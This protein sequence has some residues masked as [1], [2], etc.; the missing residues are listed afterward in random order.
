MTNGIFKDIPIKQINYA[1]QN[2]AMR[3]EHEEPSSEEMQ[4]LA[5]SLK[6]DDIIQPILVRPIGTDKYEVIAGNRR[7][8]AAKAAGLR[9]IPA[10]VRDDLDDNRARRMAFVENAIR[11][12][13]NPVQKAKGIASLY[14]GR[15]ISKEMA[16]VMVKRVHDSGS[17]EIAAQKANAKTKSE[18]IDTAEF[19]EVFNS[20][21]L[22]ANTQY[23]YLQFVTALDESVQK[24]ISEMP[25]FARTKAT[26]LTHTRL[27]KEPEVQK[28]LAH[29]IRKMNT[30]QAQETV[31]QAVHDLE[32]G[33]ITKTKYTDGSVSIH[34]Y[35][36]E[37]VHA[38]QTTA[39]GFEDFRSSSYMADL[40][41]AIKK[42]I[43]ILLERPLGRG[44][45]EYSERVYKPKIEE[46]QQGLSKAKKKDRLWLAKDA[47]VL[48][49]VCKAIMD[50]AT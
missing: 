37:N 20:I 21:P 36:A 3:F 30:K 13:L 47:V 12:E 14:A 27:R 26:M 11:K 41:G 31:R 22:A 49:R 4:Q 44:E 8:M 33:T 50:S 45:I 34:Q 24:E 1:G 32:T 19:F 46:L 29:K 7:V 5:N 10:I 48:Y 39:D 18:A 15:G 28:M 40:S 42:C 6:N 9:T 16:I 35:H 23:Q 25:G 2:V 17:L 38:K 43:G